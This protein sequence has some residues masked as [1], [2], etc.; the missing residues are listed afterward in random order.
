MKIA[1]VRQNGLRENFKDGLMDLQKSSI[2][3]LKSPGYGIVV[4]D[5]R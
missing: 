3:P 5:Q 4:V 1:V 2:N